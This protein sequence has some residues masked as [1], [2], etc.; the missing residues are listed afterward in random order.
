MSG[1]QSVNTFNE[2][3]NS[4]TYSDAFL[5]CPKWKLE[6]MEVET[7]ENSN[8]FYNWTNQTY[9]LGEYMYNAKKNSFYVCIPQDIYKLLKIVYSKLLLLTGISST[10]IYF[11]FTVIPSKKLYWVIPWTFVSLH[12]E[13]EY[14]LF[15]IRGKYFVFKSNG[16]W[17]VALVT[18]ILEAKPFFTYDVKGTLSTIVTNDG[19]SVF[20]FIHGMAIFFCRKLVYS[21][22]LLVSCIS[23]ASLTDAFIFKPKTGL[24]WTF[25]FTVIAL[26]GMCV[27]L[28]YGLSEMI[29]IYRLNKNVVCIEV[30][31]CMYTFDELGRDGAVTDGT[32]YKTNDMMSVFPRYVCRF[33]EI[34][35]ALDILQKL[36]LNVSLHLKEHWRKDWRRIE[37]DLKSSFAILFILTIK[38][39][40]FVTSATLCIICKIIFVICHL[41]ITS[42][43]NRK[44][45]KAMKDVGG[46]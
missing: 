45:Y 21:K 37:K 24:Y 35:P 15:L 32:K 43:V 28:F 11:A 20:I 33:I 41:T 34:F 6:L 17:H 26:H 18:R 30:E 12:G 1:I 16:I 10:S 23:I 36:R 13:T 40:I 27:F 25:P 42:K 7:R 19:S 5:E 9:Q 4:V 2:T 39:T 44:L 14:E 8:I 31:K 22:L 46:E 38:L 3:K 29:T